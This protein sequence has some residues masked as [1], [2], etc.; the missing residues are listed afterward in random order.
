MGNSAGQR[1][2]EPTLSV[3]VPVYNA[4]DYIGGC[5]D[6][7]LSSTLTDLEVIC[8]D[9][10]STDGS[11]DII[12]R[13][14]ES[15]DRIR[16]I[17]QEHRYAGIARNN[18]IKAATGTYVHF[19][20]ADDLVDPA[21]YQGLCEL[22]RAHDADMAEC[23]YAN[24]DAVEGS[25]VCNGSYGHMSG[26]AFPK[27][28]SMEKN[29]EALVPG[30]VA[31]WNKVYSRRFLLDN[32]IMFDDLIC[33][34]DRLFYFHAIRDAKTIVRT[35]SLWVTHRVNVS[36]SLDGSDVRL[37]HFD[38][39]FTSFERIWELYKDAPDKQREL[40]LDNCIGDSLYYYSKAVGTEFEQGIVEQLVDYWDHYVAYEGERAYGKSW[41]GPLIELAAR[42]IS[43]GYRKSIVGMYEWASEEIKYQRR[44]DK[45]R[46][47][48]Y[49]AVAAILRPV[50]KRRGR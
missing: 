37:R 17:T 29:P 3:I 14:R 25:L 2:A 50:R 38:V 20:D 19:L 46:K 32:N 10:G 7:I 26:G 12:E 22:A 9:D 47:K 23:L 30:H 4:R 13:Y 1:S 5:L 31:P 21:A 40:V 18:G 8:V 11:L 27:V 43:P 24:V 39:E 41:Y 16:L 44:S 49:G 45:V 35:D 42:R 34:E 48:V 28:V 36:T 33:A 6:S 15:D